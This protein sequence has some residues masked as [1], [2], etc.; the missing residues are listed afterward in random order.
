[1]YTELKIILFIVGII[2][3]GTFPL[4]LFYLDNIVDSIEEKVKSL[5]K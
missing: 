4:V 3:L 2:F 5:L 1:M